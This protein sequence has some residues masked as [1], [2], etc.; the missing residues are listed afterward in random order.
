MIFPQ[1]EYPAEFNDDG[2]AKVRIGDRKTGTQGYINKKG[3]FI[4]KDNQ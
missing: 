1:F 3:K 4:W 2:F